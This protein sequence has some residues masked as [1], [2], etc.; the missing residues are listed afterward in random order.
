[1]NFSRGPDFSG[2]E[3][4]LLSRQRVAY[5]IGREAEGVLQ[6]DGA[7]NVVE[8]YWPGSSSTKPKL[9]IFQNLGF[10]EGV[11]PGTDTQAWVMT[12]RSGFNEAGALALAG[13]IIDRLERH[14]DMSGSIRHSVQTL[15]QLL[16]QFQ[17]MSRGRQVGLIGEL[18]FL[19]HLAD[20]LGD[21]AA[22]R[23]WLGPPREQ[24]DF[25]LEGFDVEVKTTESDSRVHTV[26]SE[27]QLMASPGRRLFL[28]SIQISEA[29][30]DSEGFS[31][32][33]LVRDT[34]S[35]SAHAP[36]L[37][38]QRLIEAGWDDDLSNLYSSRIV[39]H[40]EPLVYSV[41]EDFPSITRSAV[42]ALPRGERVA[43]VRYRIDL[44]GFQAE[45]VFP[46][47]LRLWQERTS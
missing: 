23:S 2:L 36:E 22:V 31:L 45:D 3:E 29:G 37:L 16:E 15:K 28:L 14:D 30:S 4:A 44:T 18:L 8:I 19:N 26:S 11:F 46:E 38:E 24:H 21:E 9:R 5:K 34:R 10:R 47:S 6:V 43:Q 39:Y 17:L 1:M 27:T 41:T 13:M 40:S 32:E 33:E 25:S 12:I 7:N 20:Y 35:R 42:D